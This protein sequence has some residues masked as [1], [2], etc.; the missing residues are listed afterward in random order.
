MALINA[1]EEQGYDGQFDVAHRLEAGSELQYINP[2]CNYVSTP[3]IGIKITVMT[4]RSLGCHP[5]AGIPCKYQE[6]G[7]QCCPCRSTTCDN[8]SRRT[9]DHGG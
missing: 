6:C 4:R 2:L 7:C 1:A 8:L 5:S 9:Q 3:H